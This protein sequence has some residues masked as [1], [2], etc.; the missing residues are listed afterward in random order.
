[1]IKVI[2]IGDNV[3][4]RYIHT[5]TMYPGGNALNFTVFAG[6]LGAEAA[7]MGNFGTDAA[8]LHIQ[9]VLKNLGIDTSHCRTYE[10]ENG[11]ARV[12]I[13]GG[14]RVFLPGNGGGINKE[15]PIDFSAEDLD[16]IRGFDLI[17]SSCYSYLEGR[18]KPLLETEVP[19]SF[20]FSDK[21]SDDYLAEM[22]PMVD[23]AFLSCSDMGVDEVE[24]RLSF[25]VRSGCLFAVASRG[26]KGALFHNGDY[27]VSQSAHL[28]KP[29]DTMGAGDSFITAFLIRMLEQKA[30]FSSEEKMVKSCM[31]FAAGK[32]AE[33]CMVSGTFGFG[34]AY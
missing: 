22:C 8:A 26:D 9:K 21:L 12:S 24:D 2:G 18:M 16:Y 19:I 27:F 10:G 30:L 5:K 23:F 33:T 4:D 1:M 14:E 3:V 6:S 32:A 20:D 17:H 31:D 7:Y 13:E 28:V 34:A 15:Y 29:V 11:Y 25:A